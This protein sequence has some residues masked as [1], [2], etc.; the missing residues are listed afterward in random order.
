M[1]QGQK[2]YDSGCGSGIITACSGRAISSE[3]WTVTG[4][5]LDALKVTTN[6]VLVRYH[7]R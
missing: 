1:W 5:L 4:K 3:Y 2:C 7:H 6:D